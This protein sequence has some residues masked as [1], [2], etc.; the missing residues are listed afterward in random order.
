[1]LDFTTSPFTVKLNNIK[2]PVWATTSPYR[3]L[4]DTFSAFDSCYLLLFG[5]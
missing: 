3:V 2:Y 4:G 1:M 5:K